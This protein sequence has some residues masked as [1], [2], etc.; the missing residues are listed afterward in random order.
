MKSG[1]QHVYWNNLITKK[2]MN[3]LFFTTPLHLE[4]RQLALGN[5]D[6]FNVLNSLVADD[7]VN[8][9]M[10]I[11]QECPDKGVTPFHV[12]FS[13]ALTGNANALLILNKLLAMDRLYDRLGWNI[14]LPGGSFKGKT[15]VYIVVELA[16]RG[17]TIAKQLLE[18]ILEIDNLEW[19]TTTIALGVD[20]VKTPLHLLLM[21]AH[22][23]NNNS[24]ILQALG[25]L[26]RNKSLKW[27]GLTLFSQ[28][29]WTA[30]KDN[31]YALD[32]FE[33]LLEKIK[34]NWNEQLND[35]GF[36]LV[37]L[38]LVMV[39]QKKPQAL[40]I[41]NKLVTTDEVNWN[42]P[43]TKSGINK[44]KTPF[45][46]LVI[47]MV[48]GHVDAEI[49]KK[50]ITNTEIYWNEYANP[51]SL[52][53]K[54]VSEENTA[55]LE[56]LDFLMSSH[57]IDWNQQLHGD[58]NQV[59]T[60]LYLLM[61]A[62][63]RGKAEALLIL[64]K[65]IKIDG[66]QWDNLVSFE[67]VTPFQLLEE[68]VR[69]GVVPN[70]VLNE[71]KM[72]N[73]AGIRIVI[74]GGIAPK[75]QPAGNVPRLPQYERHQAFETYQYNHQ[76]E[77][78]PLS[79]L[80]T[81]ESHYRIPLNI[82]QK[83]IR[84]TLYT[85]RGK[86]DNSCPIFFIFA[87]RKEAALVPKVD[88]CRCVLVLTQTEYDEI[89]KNKIPF[90]LD[91]LVLH[92]LSSQTHGEFDQLQLLTARRIGVFL[93]AH[94]YQLDRFVALDDNIE[95]ISFQ[96]D[97]QLTGMKT[98]YDLLVNNLLNKA[99]ISVSTQSKTRKLREHELGSKLFLFN[100]ALI[101][102]YL[103]ELKDIFLLQPTAI[104]ANKPLEDAYFQT[105]LSVMLKGKALGY[106][107]LPKNICVLHRS[108]KNR[109]ACASIGMK[110]TEF[111]GPDMTDLLSLVQKGWLTETL[112]VINS[113]VQEK[114]QAHEEKAIL[115][116]TCDLGDAHGLVHKIQLGQ[117]VS[118]SMSSREGEFVSTYQ[119]TL[120]KWQDQK[121]IL[122]H[123]QVSAINAIANHKKATCSIVNAT[124]CG[125]SMILYILAQEA[126]PVLNQGEIIAVITPQIDLSNQ[127]YEDFKNY[128]TKFE[129]SFPL[130]R[131]ISVSSD[132]QSCSIKLLNYNDTLE[133]SKHILVFCLESYQ[134]FCETP[135][136]NDR[137]RLALYDEF[138]DYAKSL[139]ALLKE[140]PKDSLAVGCTA[141][142]P[143]RKVLN[144]PI[145]SY[146]FTQAIKDGYLAPIIADGLGMNYSAENV[147]KFIQFLPTILQHQQHPGFGKKTALTTTKGIIYLPSI[148]DCERAAKEMENA[149]IP[150]VIVHSK[151]ENRKQKIK[152]F[153]QQEFGF[154]LAV[155]MLR[156]GFNDVN[157]GCVIIAQKLNNPKKV[158][159]LNLLQQMMGRPL[160][161]LEGK[162]AYVLTFDDNKILIDN[163][164][165][166][167]P[168]V[169]LPT[170]DYLSQSNAYYIEGDKCRVIDSD[171]IS[172]ENKPL[173]TI[174]SS[175]DYCSRLNLLF[176]NSVIVKNNNEDPFTDNESDESEL[177]DDEL[178]NEEML[179]NQYSN[180]FT[181]GIKRIRKDISR[182][183]VVEVTA[184]KKPKM[185]KYE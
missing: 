89:T 39:G 47:K 54:A 136:N 101:R 29:L 86:L 175:D 109:N 120:K 117:S 50:L 104:E 99:C 113:Y 178:E 107:V 49:I 55:A 7:N 139:S 108:L 103:P 27:N 70:H 64:D 59:T 184:V 122:R 65:V 169:R 163:L 151:I 128:H 183:N 154:I 159:H 58:Q 133:K 63:R 4:T 76:Q 126:F 132:D 135:E 8:W 150:F 15:P 152:Q 51:F 31:P 96:K 61:K 155:E 174:E 71:L 23:D 102:Q 68:A 53:M 119:K 67:G 106:N 180:S 60:P 130:E 160:R 182:S 37:Y 75:Y 66:I 42:V 110:A 185:G 94:Y 81:V 158:N 41:L 146:T 22:S 153:L 87:G 82:D 143:N 40:K 138:H 168:H 125:K 3:G 91:M 56:V 2:K 69:N 93:V 43:I 1:P 13:C 95:K 179:F 165:K 166:E 79:Y 176:N 167:T 36:T 83:E 111:D 144:K 80:A 20:G 21:A 123:Y 127:M 97:G 88:N 78:I 14:P 18:K 84:A 164:L 145:F 5:V 33:K 156:F 45:Y 17:Q 131:V 34:I 72:R 73:S 129:S 62:I 85:T 77:F 90:E 9:H 98:F 44:G 48:A 124:G 147:E 16:I 121:K 105:F 112:S 52:L 118:T 92:R 142:L 170:N 28:L 114:I 157:L 140:Q 57:D 12:L 171:E 162:I 32:L 30:A 137:I 177:T 181:I 19:N 35:D 141:T 38:L 172:K 116:A 100:M 11:E 74:Q 148:S 26:A 6:A 173:F 24:L 115:T 149:N 46:M 25:K 161:N 10:A 134:K